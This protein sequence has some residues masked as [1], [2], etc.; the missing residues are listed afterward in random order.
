MPLPSRSP[1]SQP[2]VPLSRSHRAVLGAALLGATLLASIG[3]VPAAQAATTTCRTD[4]IVILSTGIKVQM[5]ATIADVS[6]N[7]QNVAYVLHA[8]RSTSVVNVAYATDNVSSIP[9]SF[10]FYADN[11]SGS[12]DSYTVTV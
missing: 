11:P 3:R 8:P 6:T 10:T 1:S 5:T 2:R 9:Q 4:P 7:V 12:Y